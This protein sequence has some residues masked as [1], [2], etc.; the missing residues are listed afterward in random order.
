MCRQT[1]GLGRGGAGAGDDHPPLPAA[2]RT[3]RRYEKSISLATCVF[4][5]GLA[6]P[7]VC[8]CACVIHPRSTAITSTTTL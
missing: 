2:R 1:G 5:V 3:A 7:Y 6:P 4:F 8:I